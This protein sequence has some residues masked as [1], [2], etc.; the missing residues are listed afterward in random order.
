MFKD[1]NE[2][3]KVVTIP[4]FITD[5]TYCDDDDYITKLPFLGTK[6]NLKVIYRGNKIKSM[7]GMFGG[8]YGSKLDL[9]DFNTSQVTDMNKMFWSCK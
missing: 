2:D 8:Y 6:Q 4:S 5:I 3:Y 1:S 7:K 9:S